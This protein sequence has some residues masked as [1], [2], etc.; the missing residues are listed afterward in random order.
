MLRGV[1]LGGVTEGNPALECEVHERSDGQDTSEGE[2]LKLRQ[3]VRSR[4]KVIGW[5]RVYR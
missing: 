5:L 3:S 4:W 2:C 1:E